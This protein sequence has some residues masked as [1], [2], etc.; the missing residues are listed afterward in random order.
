MKAMDLFLREHAFVHSEA[1][2]RA[3]ILNMPDHLREGMGDA[4]SQMCPH[5]MNSFVWHFWHIARAEDHGAS[6][7]GGSEQTLDREG[8]SER[9]GVATRDTGFGMPKDEVGELSKIINVPEHL[10]LP[11]CGG[12]AYEGDGLRTVV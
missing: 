7:V 1:F 2:A 4:E 10:G 5:G 3:E 6:I 9:L 8:W 11:E 12:M